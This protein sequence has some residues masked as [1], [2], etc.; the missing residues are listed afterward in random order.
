MK[1]IT[2]KRLIHSS[3]AFMAAISFHATSAAFGQQLEP[4]TFRAALDP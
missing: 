1:H 2:V 4:F 3:M